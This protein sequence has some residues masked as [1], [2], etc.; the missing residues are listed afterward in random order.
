MKKLALLVLLAVSALILPG[1]HTPE[2]TT[3]T[4]QTHTIRAAP[5]T[6]TTTTVSPY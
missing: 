5:T 6:E 2:T 4:T 1:C 3:T